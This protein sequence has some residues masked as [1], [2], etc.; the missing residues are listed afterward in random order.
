MI[1]AFMARLRASNPVCFSCWYHPSD[2]HGLVYLQHQF[3]IVSIVHVVDETLRLCLM[4]II[5][6][7]VIYDSCSV[8][9]VALTVRF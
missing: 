6:S 9:D 8:I 4:F 7:E 1:I 5:F 3:S 2:C